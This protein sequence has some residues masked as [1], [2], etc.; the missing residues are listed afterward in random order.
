VIVR[1]T[2]TGAAV[3]HLHVLFAVRA[4][5]A[6]VL[7]HGRAVPAVDVDE[8]TRCA[9]YGT[10]RDVVAIRLPCCGTFYPCHLCHAAVADHDAERWPIDRRGEPAVLCGAWGAEVAIQEYLGVTGCPACETRFNPGC[11]DHYGR[12][13]ETTA[14]AGEDA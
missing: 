9:H 13:V 5:S 6:T 11:A 7:V 10:E 8:E 2:V 1:G 12:Y 3:A 4:T 14:D